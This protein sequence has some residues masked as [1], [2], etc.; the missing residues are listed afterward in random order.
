MIDVYWIEQVEA[1][2]PVDDYWLSANEA[3]RLNQMRFAK[4]KNDWRLGRWTAKRALSICWDIPDD[5]GF[6][7][8][9]EICPADT[10]APQVLLSNKPAGVTISISHSSGKAVCAITP[11]EAALGCD[12]EMI[13]PRSECFI[14]D[15]FTPDE[16]S[17][18]AHSLAEERDRVSTLLWSAKE[19][20]LKAL[21]T[22]LRMD[23]WSVIVRPHELSAGE[24]WHPLEASAAG[25]QGFHG[26]WKQ[27]DGFLR[28]LVS[29]PQANPPI[30]RTA[31]AYRG[32]RA[33]LFN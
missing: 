2:V 17:L 4:R 11:S 32:M 18:V 25:Y 14:G 28:T 15:Y 20:T 33:S 27:A 8:E 7:P 12:L 24:G 6:F 22:G 5:F 29:A 13:E 3:C 26:W 1:D 19:S 31:P 10:G 9:I 23:T 16:Q 30:C 21:Q